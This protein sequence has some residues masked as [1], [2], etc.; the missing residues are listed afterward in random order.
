MANKSI[1][2]SD[3]QETVITGCIGTEFTPGYCVFGQ[4]CKAHPCSF[5]NNGYDSS[6]N[7]MDSIETKV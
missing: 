4:G 3:G 7:P 6:V 2:A 1:N 5:L